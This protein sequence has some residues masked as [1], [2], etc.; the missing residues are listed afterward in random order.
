MLTLG[1]ICLSHYVINLFKSGPNIFGGP[2]A[3]QKTSNLVQCHHIMPSNSLLVFVD[4][5]MKGIRH[6]SFI[7]AC[8]DENFIKMVD[9]MFY[10]FNYILN[11]CHQI[12]DKMS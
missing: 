1:P 8:L 12:E 6:Q 3:P 11:G 5:L 2:G 7:Y 4:I 10:C 9:A